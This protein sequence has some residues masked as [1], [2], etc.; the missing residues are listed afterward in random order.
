MDSDFEAYCWLWELQ[1]VS[2]CGQLVGE[3]CS[4][5]WESSGSGMEASWVV[6]F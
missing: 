3:C 4:S 5:E 2:L 6:S 1:T